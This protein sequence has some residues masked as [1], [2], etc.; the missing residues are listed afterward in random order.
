MSKS[1][2]LMELMMAVNRKRRFKVQELADEFG[3]SA[4]TILR[5]LQ[6]LSELGVPLYSEVGPHGGYQVIRERVLPPIA[7]TE[8]E[9][10]ALFF[11]CQA[12]RHYSALPFETESSCALKKFYYYMPGDVRDRIDQM[13]N[14]VDF[15]SPIRQIE[16]PHLAVL[17]DAAVG[18]KVVRIEYESRE[19]ASC[20]EIQP[21]GIYA[22]NG[23]W[24]CPAYCFE[25]Q[26]FR[27]FR[28]DR[29]R[30]VGGEPAVSKPLDL[31]HVHIGN[32]ESFV[33]KGDAYVHVYVELSKEG[34]QRCEPELGRRGR[35][36]VREDGSG[37]LEGDVPRT[38]IPFLAKFFIGLGTEAKVREPRE[39]IDCMKRNLSEM[40]NHLLQ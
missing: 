32:W 14:R 24:Y 37:W 35:L 20:R 28:C 9:A 12:L 11:A 6:E 30:S 10:V 8:E 17:L 33:K 27:L 23:F 29:I 36:H 13:R 18:Q 31:R 40:M 26:Q 25:R 22:S 34:V 7:F 4:R 15:L 39:L 1:K 3:V 16:S 5:D 2:R 38:E 19:G 21:L